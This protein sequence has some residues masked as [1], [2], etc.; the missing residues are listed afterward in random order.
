[1]W[2]QHW[3]ANDAALW[4][5]ILLATGA[6]YLLGAIPM[7]YLAGKAWGVDVTKTA[8]G[9]TGGTNVWRATGKALPPLLTVLGDVAKGVAAVLLAR[10]FLH[11]ELAA[12][13]AGAAAVMGHNWSVLL[14][15]RGG[16][17]GVTAGAA[18]LALS[19]LAAAVVVP[20]AI[21]ALYLSRY[22]SVG[23][24]TVAVGGAVV[25]G[26]LALVAPATQV[27]VHLIFGLASAAAVVIS[28][29]PNLKRLVAGTERR[30]TLW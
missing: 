16:A 25:L 24:L 13:A 17:G 12:A 26:V 2:L 6:G 30:I 28:L 10:Y 15:F 1:M 7:G 18:L 29:R 5:R 23:T 21:V 3:L 27:S 20:L 11:S 8:S 9:R 14:G 19:P 22:A 4:L